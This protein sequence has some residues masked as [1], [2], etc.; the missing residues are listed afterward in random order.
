[1]KNFNYRKNVFELALSEDY[2]DR[3]RVAINS[4][5]PIELLCHLS[6]DGNAMIRFHVAGN[7]NTPIR[8][9][10][11]LSRDENYWVYTHVVGNPITPKYIVDSLI[12]GND[13][14]I[15][16]NIACANVNENILEELSHDEDEN[17]QCAVARNTNTS[18]HTLD[19]LSVSKSVCIREAV[20]S[21][22][23]VSSKTLGALSNDSEESV[24]LN[25]VKNKKCDKSILCNLS[26]SEFIEIKEEAKYCLLELRRLSC[27]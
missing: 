23:N 3:I 26:F 9:L 2:N 20:A 12:H 11:K 4:T 8:V 22:P 16:Y 25:V 5:A 13:A 24:L 21:N 18:P 1:M 17:V 7:S 15:R 14:H 6:N 19:N 27:L 10:E